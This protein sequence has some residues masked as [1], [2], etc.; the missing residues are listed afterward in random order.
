MIARVVRLTSLF[1][2][3]F[4]LIA[5]ESDNPESSIRGLY[6]IEV[7]LL[8]GKTTPLHY[9]KK[10]ACVF[11]FISAGCP[12]FQ[13]YI[14]KV[15][16]LFSNYKSAGIEFV[17]VFP[18][19]PTDSLERNLFGLNYDVQFP[20]VSDVDFNFAKK[21]NATVT[22]EVVL[23]D[24]TMNVL[25]QGRIDNWFERLGSKRP[26]TTKN[27]LKEAM[28]AYLIGQEYSIRKTK[29]VGCYIFPLKTQ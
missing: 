6:D 19:A 2:A 13:Q 11:I 4:F 20:L 10:K 18:G 17:G 1:F 12:I 21:L 9:L 25:Y 23:I 22:P 15:N 24:S 28:D 14:P 27:N 3:L 16:A 26:V 5:C 8:D 7:C 29:P